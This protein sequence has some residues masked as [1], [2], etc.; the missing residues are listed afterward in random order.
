MRR[1]E[2]SASNVVCVLVNLRLEKKP[3]PQHS[4]EQQT[5][6]GVSMDE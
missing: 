3:G 2:S 1:S 5:G 4:Y 6:T